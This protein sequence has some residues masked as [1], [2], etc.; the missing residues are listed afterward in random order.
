MYRGVRHL[1]NNMRMR[2]KLLFSYVLIVMI[3]VLVVGGCVTF[4][5]RQQALD[6]A[7][8]QTVN[9]V[10]KIKSQTANLLRV[11]TDISN[12]LMFDKRLK[13]MAN[14]RYSG[15]V[16]L[17]NAYHQYKDFNEY[18][19]QYREIATIRFYS[20]NPTLVNNLEFIPVDSGIEQRQWFKT[21]LKGTAKVRK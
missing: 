10:E 1:M 4:Y 3:P 5:L 7:I 2:N 6:S 12:G 11:P 19:Q 8:A 21:A 20:Y 16:E 18:V 13:E 9:N 15:M 17:M 14:R